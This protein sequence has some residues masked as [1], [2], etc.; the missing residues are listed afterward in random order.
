M[1]QIIRTLQY[2][3]ILFYNKIHGKSS[4]ESF[5]YQEIE[6]QEKRDKTRKPILKIFNK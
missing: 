4:F 3:W 6:D 5:P 1:K 2:F